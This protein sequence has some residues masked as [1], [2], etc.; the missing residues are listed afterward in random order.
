MYVF[1]TC[2]STIDLRG[3]AAGAASPLEPFDGA[4]SSLESELS[5]VNS[6]QQPDEQVAVVK[7][8]VVLGETEHPSITV[9][10][11]E[12]VDVAVVVPSVSTP[13]DT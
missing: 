8:V 3:L 10:D 6:G 2:G 4:S 11:V 5:Y 12:Y 13:Y 1:I 9:D 7:I